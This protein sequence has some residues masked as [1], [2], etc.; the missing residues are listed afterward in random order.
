MHV[1]FVV[2]AVAGEGTKRMGILLD[3][4]IGKGALVVILQNR[5]IAQV[6]FGQ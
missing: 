1:Q 6:T 4:E 3:E 5:L 2:I